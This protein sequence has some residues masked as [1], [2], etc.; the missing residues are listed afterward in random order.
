M[1]AALADWY[2]AIDL[3]EGTRMG[4]ILETPP[5]DRRVLVIQP[6]D[7]AE[8]RTSAVN[9][10]QVAAAGLGVVAHGNLALWGAVEAVKWLRKPSKEDPTPAVRY[11]AATVAEASTELQLTAGH[12]ILDH[13]YAM[14]PLVSDRYIT[15]ASFHR[16]LFEEKVNELM[17]L[18]ASL[19]ATRA[20]VVCQKGY[21]KS[22]GAEAGGVD[23]TTGASAGVK[24]TSSGHQHAIIE[25][26]FA[27][28]GEPRLPDDLVWFGNEQS[29]QAL[30]KR[31]LSFGTKTFKTSLSYEDN[32]GVD[33]SLKVGLEEC[34]FK[35]GGSFSDF[36]STLWEFEGEFADL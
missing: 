20:K 36:E 18:I 32:F 25:E 34:N 16:Y 30:A 28:R 12:P 31:R 14:H 9:W 15:L 33:A 8:V 13:A 26:H 24:A 21:R 29:W 19:G 4:R 17:N 23:P 1:H 6:A 7:K 27:P 22:V 35:I 11:F 3:L 5:S 2:D 10:P